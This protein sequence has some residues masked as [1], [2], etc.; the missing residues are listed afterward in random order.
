[1]ATLLLKKTATRIRGL[2]RQEELVVGQPL[3]NR[4]GPPAHASV[5]HGTRQIKFAGPL[6]ER[7]L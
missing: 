5:E 3:F 1:M 2:I 7:V 6:E 4:F